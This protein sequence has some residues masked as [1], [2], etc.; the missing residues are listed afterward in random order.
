MSH[1]KTYPIGGP[2]GGPG[3]KPGWNAPGGGKPGGPLSGLVKA[4][5]NDSSLW[6]IPGGAPGIWNSIL[7]CSGLNRWFS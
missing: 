6:L 2:P 5:R 4:P 3:G 1:R 7:R